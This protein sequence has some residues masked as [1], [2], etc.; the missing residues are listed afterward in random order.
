[1]AAP[2]PRPVPERRVAERGEEEVVQ[3]GER[4]T[5]RP[6]RLAGVE[7]LLEEEVLRVGVDERPRRDDP[8]ALD[9]APRLARQRDRVR[10]SPASR[11]DTG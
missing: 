5:A 4:G 10:P 1:M 3:A 9:D 6:R 8:L 7:H 11:P 2:E